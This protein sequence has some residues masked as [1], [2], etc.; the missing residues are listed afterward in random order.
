[1]GYQ[2]YREECY[3]KIRSQGA[4]SGRKGGAREKRGKLSAREVIAEAVRSSEAVPHIMAPSPPRCIFG[5]D[6]GELPM[7]LDQLEACADDVMVQTTNGERHQRSDTPIL[8]GV[9]ASYPRPASDSDKLYVEWRTKA[10]EF[11][12]QRYGVRLVSVLE[13]RDEA[14]GH[15]HGFVADS[16]RSVKPWHAGHAATLAS[17]RRGEAKKTQSD[18]YKNGMRALQDAFFRSVGIETGLAR[19]G[20]RKPRKS[21]AAWQAEKQQNIATALSINVEQERCHDAEL[22]KNAADVL[23]QKAQIA[24][25]EVAQRSNAESKALSLER[26]M[27]E[28]FRD[29]LIQ[30]QLLNGE[31]EKL[32]AD[33]LCDASVIKLQS[34]NDRLRKHVNQLSGLVVGKLESASSGH[35]AAHSALVPK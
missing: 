17:K 2:F 3:A 21:R 19:I 1:M 28:E 16:G 31:K 35:P 15:I 20:P 23:M 11:M 27:L 32:L 24:A 18:E 30:L 14:F 10:L 5:V 9:V 26:I 34:E 6:D 33:A 25:D 29:K 7:W 4:P 13:H 22:R 8:M 12:Q